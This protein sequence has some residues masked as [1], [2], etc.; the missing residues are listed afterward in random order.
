MFV[1][2]FL[3]KRGINF[4]SILMTKLSSYHDNMAILNNPCYN[5]QMR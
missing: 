4:A 3:N 2:R 1:K 5:Q